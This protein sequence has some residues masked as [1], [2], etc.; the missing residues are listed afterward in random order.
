MTTSTATK[1]QAQV[2]TWTHTAT[3]LS[4][5]IMGSLSTILA[6]LQLDLTKLTGSWSLYQNGIRVWLAEESLEA[7]VLECTG[8]D[9]VLRA[10][11]EFPAKYST[12]V[13]GDAKFVHDHATL[14]AYMAKL[15]Q[16]PSGCSYR[17]LITYRRTPTALAGWSNTSRLSTDGMK[18]RVF[19]TV[20]AGPHASANLR[21][22][23]SL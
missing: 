19:G 7:V 6:T 13:A 15:K 1:T 12:D 11:F 5:A 23:Y 21:Y 22:L 16:L 17:I 20:A 8:P 3:H 18:A 4:D 10:V 2:A 14:A 9:N